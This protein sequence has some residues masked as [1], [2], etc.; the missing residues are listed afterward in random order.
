MAILVLKE[1][2]FSF[3]LH[4]HKCDFSSVNRIYVQP[5]LC[6]LNRKKILDTKMIQ[7]VHLIQHVYIH[8]IVKRHGLIRRQN[9]LLSLKNAIRSSG[10]SHLTPVYI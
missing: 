7:S 10:E 8:L 9:Q 3:A 2:S 6:N 1:V 4:L 5:K